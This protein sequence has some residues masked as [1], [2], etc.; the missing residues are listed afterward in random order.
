MIRKRM[1]RRR[2]RRAMRARRMRRARRVRRVRRMRRVRTVR[3]VRRA[4]RAR[5]AKKRKSKMESCLNSQVSKSK[6]S[7]MTLLKKTRLG[8][9][10]KQVKEK[11]KNQKS[12]Y[13]RRRQKLKKCQ[14]HC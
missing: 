11:I 7:G 13:I 10:C 9:K 3:T 2:V 8:R 14:M 1:K 4:R 5:R 12:Q 6:N